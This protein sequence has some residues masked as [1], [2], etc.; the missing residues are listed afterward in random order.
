[1]NASFLVRSDELDMGM[2]PASQEELIGP[3]GRPKSRIDKLL[4]EAAGRFP[5]G[6]KY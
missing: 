6:K 1:M 3:G 2:T 5:Y 4:R